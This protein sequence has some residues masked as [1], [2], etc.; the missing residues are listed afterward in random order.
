MTQADINDREGLILL[1]GKVTASLKRLKKIWSDMGYAGQGI[2]DKAQSLGY[3]LSNIKRR[4]KWGWFPKAVEP[5]MGSKNRQVK[6]IYGFQVLT[7]RWVVERT[8]AW[9]GRYRRFSKEYE[10]HCH[11]SE[12]MP[13]AAMTKAI[14]ARLAKVKI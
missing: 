2:R 8:C 10:Y 11:T 12:M 7:K 13:F 6:P 9:L 4:R 14:V 5:H 1:L 3:S